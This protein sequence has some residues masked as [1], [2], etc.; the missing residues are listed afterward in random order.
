MV[1]NQAHSTEILSKNDDLLWREKEK[2]I[3]GKKSQFIDM[4]SELLLKLTISYIR[5]FI[6]CLTFAQISN[7]AIGNWGKKIEDSP[8]KKS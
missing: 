7:F 8:D 2:K 1:L 4:Q 5:I 3:N 6:S